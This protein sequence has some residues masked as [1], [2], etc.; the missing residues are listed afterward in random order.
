[1]LRHLLCLLGLSAFLPAILV[2]GGPLETFDD[3]VASLRAGHLVTGNF[4]TTQCE[5]SSVPEPI[6]ASL[7]Y[8]E[9][10]YVDTPETGLAIT[11]MHNFMT[12]DGAFVIVFSYVTPS[13]ISGF[14]AYQVATET[15]LV[16]DS[17]TA[18]CTLGTGA[19][20]VEKDN[21]Q[22]DTPVTS[23]DDLMT[24]L[25]EGRQL[26][27][28]AVITDCEHSLPPEVTLA[29]SG[30]TYYQYYV[31]SDAGGD[32]VLI[33]EWPGLSLSA[34]EGET[35]Y[36]VIRATI[37]QDGSTHITAHEYNSLTW[38]DEY[39]YP[40]GFQ[41]VLGD[42]VNV[43][44]SSED[45]IDTLGSY[46]EV[47]AAFMEGKDLQASVDVSSCSG[48]FPDGLM[49]AGAI[50]LAWADDVGGETPG[51]HFSQ[52]IANRN[53]NHIRTVFYLKVISVFSAPHSSISFPIE[54]GDVVIQ[55]FLLGEDGVLQVLATAFN[56]VDPGDVPDVSAFTC[57]IGDGVTFTAPAY[58]RVELTT[59]ASVMEAQLSGSK[60]TAEIDFSQCEDPTGELDLTG[61]TAGAYFRYVTILG[62]GTPEERMFGSGFG[63]HSDPNSGV[64]YETFAATVDTSNNALAYPG[65]WRADESGTWGNDFGE[66]VLECALG[67]GIMIFGE[68]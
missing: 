12:P 8:D 55:E 60:L 56:P 19:T 37:S 67:A 3:V 59:Y 10:Q 44:Y 13:G 11:G 14:N 64:A 46:D 51:I 2:Q 18:F 52:S 24:A 43:Y 35:V 42:N 7:H 6:L 58:N 32:E 38:E 49:V 27:L 53:K 4:D 1:M 40:E 50:I 9:W 61:L 25:T 15:G 26:V 47:E 16:Q 66:A 5:D 48:T 21:H 34:N 54:A 17:F 68:A 28:T 65:Y 57:D 41:C 62:F 33:L 39:P 63:V 30:S 20:F 45:T 31:L 36:L 22:P 23:Y 29:E